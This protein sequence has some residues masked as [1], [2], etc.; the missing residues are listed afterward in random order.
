MIVKLLLFRHI[1]GN[2]N[3]DLLRAMKFAKA[4]KRKAL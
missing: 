3:E 4:K 1:S 2:E